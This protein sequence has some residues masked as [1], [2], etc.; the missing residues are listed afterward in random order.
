MPRLELQG[1][2]PTFEDTIFTLIDSVLLEANF[3]LPAKIVKYYPDL[4]YADVQIQ[5][6]TKYEDGTVKALPTLPN[7]PVKWP[8]ANGGKSFIHLPLAIGDDVTLVF[9]QRS[10]D[11]WKTQGGMQDPA[12]RRKFHLSDAVALVGGSAEPDAFKV[13]D[14]LSIELVNGKTYVKITPD[15]KFQAKNDTGEL[16]MALHD[17]IVQAKKIATTLSTDTTNTL[18]GPQLL[19]G[20]PKYA[21]VAAALT[22]LISTLESFVV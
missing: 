4:Q 18:L 16:V 3:C 15:G 19:L 21:A 6:K 20:A 1:V 7:I 11:N 17:S 2:N 13:L 12:D 22:T 14:P 8:R 9:A 5:L 10:L